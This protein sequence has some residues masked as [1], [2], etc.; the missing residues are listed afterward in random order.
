MTGRSPNLTADR[1]G[2]IVEIIRAWDGRLTWPGLIKVVSEKTH[3]TYT[4]QALYKHE[5]IRIAYETYKEKPNDGDDGRPVPAALQ[6]SY[7]RVKRL[8]T[9]KRN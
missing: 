1:I 3:A 7:E 5:A 6:A 8:E 2:K 4:R 9:E